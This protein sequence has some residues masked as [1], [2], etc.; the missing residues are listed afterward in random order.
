MEFTKGAE[1]LIKTLQNSGFEA[2]AVGGAVRDF[3]R[4]VNY[5]DVDITTS[6]TPDEM[7]EV[8]KDFKVYPTGI[9]HGTVT[10]AV[11]G[12]NIEI[13]T[14]RTEKGYSDNRRPDEVVFVRSLVEDLK[15]RDF[16]INAMAYNEEKGVVDLFGGQADLQN[17]IIKTVGNPDERFNED[18]L[19]ILRGLRFASVL[20]F[21]IETE[22]KIQ[23]EF[24]RLATW[25]ARRLW[26]I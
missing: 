21:E 3:L 2:Y 7:L 6:A 14:F 9:K 22:D 26:N 8:F 13:T 4:G 18:A 15:R 19:R 10:V 25:L 11:D 5:S 17:K 16:T 24:W 12:E 20:D 23:C 1:N